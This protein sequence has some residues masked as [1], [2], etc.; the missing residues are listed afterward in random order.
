MNPLSLVFYFIIIVPSSIIHEYMHGWV[1]NQLGDPTAKY[2]GRLSLDPRVHIDKIGTLL[3]PLAL[4]FMTGGSFMFAYAKPVP[5]NPYNLRD[6]R[7]GPMWVAIAGPVANFLLALV[8]L[9]L[10]VLCR[11]MPS[12]LFCP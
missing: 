4:F 5:Y 12:V 11:A 8:L 3:L 9:C 2:A 7:L 6:Q 10:S 1:A